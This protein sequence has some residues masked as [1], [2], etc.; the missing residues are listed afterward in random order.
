[1]WLT[2]WLCG[3]LAAVFVVPAL[4]RADGDPAS[5][6]LVGQSLYVPSDGGVLATQ[7][8]RLSALLAEA[9]R[10]GVPVR[11]ALIATQADLGSVTELWR[12]P[13]NYARF[14]GQELSQV[15]RGTLVVVMPAGIGVAGAGHTSGAAAPADVAGPGQPLVNRAI[16]AVQAIAAAQGHRLSP[17]S[18]V[19]ARRSG[20][21]LGSVDL[22][23]WLALGAGAAL[24][25]AAWTA[26][27]RARPLTRQ[28]RAR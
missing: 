21:G 10:A 3:V 16:G 19:A 11:V 7:A 14:L 9:E 20:S 25:A 17:P 4:A 24:I 5:D 18:V 8:A 28:R 6:V 22:G 27:L 23:S 26:S 1:M 2:R 13:Q 12:Q 15:Y